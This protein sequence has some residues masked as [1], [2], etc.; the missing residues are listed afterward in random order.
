MKNWGRSCKPFW[1]RVTELVDPGS[2]LNAVAGIVG[3][4]VK[5]LE[6]SGLAIQSDYEQS[7]KPFFKV[8]QE[9]FQFDLKILT[10]CLWNRNDDVVTEKTEVSEGSVLHFQ[11][12]YH[13]HSVQRSMKLC[14][15]YICCFVWKFKAPWN[16]SA[17][18]ATDFASFKQKG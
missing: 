2:F 12:I 6:G 16:V 14:E 7:I 5:G 10:V 8:V 17:P 18:S 11:T 1:W 9:E 13:L 4:L 15:W 3:R